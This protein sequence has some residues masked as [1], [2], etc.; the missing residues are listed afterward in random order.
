MIWAAALKEFLI[1]NTSFLSFQSLNQCS[2][3]IWST[4]NDMSSHAFQM[5]V[6]LIYR[7]CDIGLLMKTQTFLISYFLFPCYYDS[8]VFLIWNQLLSFSSHTALTAI[9]HI[10]YVNVFWWIYVSFMETKC[11]WPFGPCNKIS[12]YTET[13]ST[14]E[15][16]NIIVNYHESLSTSSSGTRSFGLFLPASINQ[17]L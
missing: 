5:S 16:L 7:I 14:V 1:I 10:L 15:A 4:E 11:Q 13:S 9:F 8:L 6:K 3:Q 17:S 12:S 2:N